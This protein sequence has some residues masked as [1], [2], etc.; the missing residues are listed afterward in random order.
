MPP[1]MPSTN[2]T[3]GTRYQAAVAEMRERVEVPDIVALEF[4]T[5]AA[6]L[7]EPLQDRL[8]IAERVAEDR[9][10]RRLQKLRLP[11]VLPV[12]RPVEHR[13]EAKIHR[14][15]VERAHFRLGRQRR[16]HAVLQRHQRG[17]AGGDVDHRIAR[18]LDDGQEAHEDF[19]IGG[20]AAV[21]R[22]AGVQMQD[23]GAG[24]RR[25]DGLRRDVL[26]LVRKMR[27]HGGRVH[28]A[29][30]GAGD[31]DLLGFHG[32]PLTFAPA[33]TARRQAAPA[34]HRGS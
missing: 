23:R 14:A 2:W 10:A 30:Y 24:L 31:D 12:P 4:E 25:V 27:R 8:D 7:A 22:V 20:R 29:R 21:F 32:L 6:A 28:R 11:G 34:S 13:V 33:A 26:R 15:H 9:V 19:R 17:A 18:L 3:K 1:R 5:G 16:R